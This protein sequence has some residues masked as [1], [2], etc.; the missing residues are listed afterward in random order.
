MPTQTELT[1]NANDA[2]WAQK[3]FDKIEPTRDAIQE[4]DASENGKRYLS[5]TGIT[6]WANLGGD[7]LD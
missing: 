3:Q 5:I 1:T 4:F 6:M 7:T 2:R